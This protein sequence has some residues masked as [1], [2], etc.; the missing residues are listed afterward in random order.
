MR[1]EMCEGRQRSLVSGCL[2][3]QHPA[4]EEVTS[5]RREPKLMKAVGNAEATFWP[6]SMGIEG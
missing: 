2:A 6:G 5:F 4:A 1:S 3:Y